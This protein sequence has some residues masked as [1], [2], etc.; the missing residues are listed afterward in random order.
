MQSL[1]RKTKISW[2]LIERLVYTDN[3]RDEKPSLRQWGRSRISNSN[4]PFPP[5][6]RRQKER[7]KC[8]QTLGTCQKLEQWQACLTGDRSIEETHLL[9]EDSTEVREGGREIS[10]LLPTLQSP[11]SARRANMAPQ[12]YWAEQG[13]GEKWI[14]GW[15][16]P[17]LVHAVLFQVLLLTYWGNLESFPFSDLTSFICKMG[18][19]G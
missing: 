16:S 19:L 7:K 4:K 8:Y 14:C 10:W 18:R 13:K 11:F 17:E 3:G 1:N 15:I 6:S 12:R 9:A 2:N 5:R